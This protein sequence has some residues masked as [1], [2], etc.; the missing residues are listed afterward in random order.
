MNSRTIPNPKIASA[1]MLILALIMLATRAFHVASALHLPDATWALFFLAGIYL[2]FASFGILLLEAVAIDVIFL[3]NGGNDYCFSIAYGFLVIAYLAL[4]L[5]G[6]WVARLRREGISLLLTGVAAWFVASGAA[7]LLTNGSFY[8]LSGKAINPS[9]E[10]WLQNAELWAYGFI[11]QPM[12]YLVAAAA[13]H[14]IAAQLKV[15]APVAQ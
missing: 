5:G 11:V 6:S 15:S 8:W 3:L 1:I 7:Y 13:A 14:F 10:G 9:L 12:V 2:G 4:W